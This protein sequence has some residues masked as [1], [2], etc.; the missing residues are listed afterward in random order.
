MGHLR[1][2]H[3]KLSGKIVFNPQL[4]KLVTLQHFDLQSTKVP[5]LKDLKLFNNILSIYKTEWQLLGICNKFQQACSTS[6]GMLH[7]IYTQLCD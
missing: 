3:S 7:Y 5:L 4:L 1:L 2:V 6:Q